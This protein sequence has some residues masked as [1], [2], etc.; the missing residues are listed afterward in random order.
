MKR[1]FL[2]F[3]GVFSMIFAFCQADSTQAPYLRFPTY[4]P[5]KLL[6]TDSATYFTKND[7]DKKSQ[8]LLMVFNPTCEHCRHETQAI[9][10]NIDAFKDIQIVMATNMPFDSMMS[11]RRTY[12]LGQYKNIVVTQDVHYFLPTFYMMHNLPFL[13][14]YDRHKKLISV[15]EGAMPI[16]KVLEQFGKM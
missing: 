11:F 12:G 14:F 2:L 1:I 8:V 5:V 3:A 16:E 4:P 13:A 6:N 10:K 9:L 15:F 7:L